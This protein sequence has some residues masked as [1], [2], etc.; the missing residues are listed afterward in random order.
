M[1]LLSALVLRVPAETLRLRFYNDFL[2]NKADLFPPNVLMCLTCLKR[3]YT[4]QLLYVCRK[5][6]DKLFQSIYVLL[7]MI[8]SQC[9]KVGLWGCKGG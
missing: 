9:F 5:Y 2:F 4:Q 8:H 6:E 7:Y 3:G 1:E